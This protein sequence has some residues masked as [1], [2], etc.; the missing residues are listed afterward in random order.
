MKF[1]NKTIKYKNFSKFTEALANSQVNL[2]FN[3]YNLDTTY[4]EVDSLMNISFVVVAPEANSLVINSVATLSQN[5]IY[6]QKN[7]I[8]E[9]YLKILKILE[10]IC[11]V[12]DI[13]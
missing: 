12:R 11:I 10:I 8:I 6:V 4:Q 7:S 13:K 5:T 1:L 3:Y 2:Y 9:K